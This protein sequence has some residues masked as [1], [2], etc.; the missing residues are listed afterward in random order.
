MHAEASAIEIDS[1]LPLTAGTSSEGGECKKSTLHHDQETHDDPRSLAILILSRILLW[2]PY[3]TLAF[4]SFNYRES[5][6]LEVQAPL[7]SLAVSNHGLKEN[8]SYA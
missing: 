1:K 4:T 7:M 8:S 5:L 3:E 6:A 2:L